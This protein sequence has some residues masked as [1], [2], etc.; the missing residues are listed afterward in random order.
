MSVMS[1]TTTQPLPRK[2]TNTRLGLAD[3]DVTGT[4]GHGFGLGLGD[5]IGVELGGVG[6]LV[7]TGLGLGSLLTMMVGVG[8]N[9]AAVGVIVPQPTVSNAAIPV[10]RSQPTVFISI[11]RRAARCPG[12]S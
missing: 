6:E 2:M 9:F 3:G 10:S 8:L 11:R 4:A 5:A 7:A 12:R 1:R